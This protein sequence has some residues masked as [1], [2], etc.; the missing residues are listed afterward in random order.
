VCVNVDIILSFCYIIQYNKMSFRY[1]AKYEY[2]YDSLMID[3]DDGSDGSDGSDGLDAQWI[4]EFENK[5]ILSDYEMMLPADIRRVSFQFVYLARDK[6][7]IERVESLS[8][9]YVLQRPNE[10]SQS[11]LFH[12]IHRYQKGT[13]TGSK[14]YYNFKSLLFYDFRIPGGSDGRVDLRWLADYVGFGYNGRDDDE[15]G[16]IIEYDNILSIEKIVFSPLISMFH[17]LIGFT[18]LLYED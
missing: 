12:I 15:Y 7:S 2:D 17:S 3:D 13:K 16:T 9:V 6:V 5:L 11:E 14:K 8:P 18:V 10:I 1:D 4:V